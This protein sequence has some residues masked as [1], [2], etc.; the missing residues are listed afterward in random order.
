MENS[1]CISTIVPIIMEVGVSKNR[2]TPR[3]GWFI[4]KNPI[5]MDDL[6]GTPIFRNIQVKT[7]TPLN[8]SVLSFRLIFHGTMIMVERVTSGASGAVIR[9]GN[10]SMQYFFH[11]HA[12]VRWKN[13]QGP[14]RVVY[15][16]QA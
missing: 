9:I 3:N 2:G 15:Y 5:K 12:L 4:M 16:H 7:W 11:L 10:C 6:G 1:G 13:H 8:I 14:E